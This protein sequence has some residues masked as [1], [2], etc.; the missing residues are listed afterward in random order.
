MTIFFYILLVFG[1]IET[2]A[3]TTTI[4]K[5]YCFAQDYHFE[6]KYEYYLLACCIIHASKTDSY[7]F[8]ATNKEI[9]FIAENFKMISVLKDNSIS[10]LLKGDLE[11]IDF[12]L[13]NFEYALCSDD[14]KCRGVEDDSK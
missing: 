4:L 7:T 6:D 11:D 5:E 14:S 10:F 1:L 2:E 12:F 13:I 8:M 9:T 3:K